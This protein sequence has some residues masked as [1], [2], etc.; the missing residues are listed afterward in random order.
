[1]RSI[2]LL[3]TLALLVFFMGCCGLTNPSG[4]F[5]TFTGDSCGGAEVPIGDLKSYCSQINFDAVK[6]TE[7]NGNYTVTGIE[8]LQLADFK[9]NSDL[10]KSSDYICMNG[11]LFS[12]ETVIQCG[13][14]DNLGAAL[15]E[16]PTGGKIQQIVIWEL[17]FDD[18]T[19]KI[20]RVDC[21]CDQ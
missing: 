12:G 14:K 6:V 5:N 13:P 1:M 2:L 7:S 20:K 4:G 11:T 17:Q 16:R 9:K 19:K 21:W 8:D 18:T 10:L 15:F 3:G